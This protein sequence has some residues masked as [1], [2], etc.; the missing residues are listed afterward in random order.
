[1]S[2]LKAA[3]PDIVANQDT[4]YKILAPIQSTYLR[5]GAVLRN[6]SSPV[7]NWKIVN[8]PDTEASVIGS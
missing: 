7:A 5:A 8:S 6:N 3:I 2:G 1:M 4:G